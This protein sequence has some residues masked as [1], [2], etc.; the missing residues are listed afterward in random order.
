MREERETAL[1]AARAQKQA[2]ESK[3]AQAHA[4]P[5]GA[6]RL[7]SKYSRASRPQEREDQSLSLKLSPSPL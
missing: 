5:G 3:A 1:M 2:L 7:Y 6:A 4:T